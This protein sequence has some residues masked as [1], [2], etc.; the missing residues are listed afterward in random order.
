[1]GHCVL[2]WKELL[3]S[4]TRDPAYDVSQQAEAF[5]DPTE[6]DLQDLIGNLV[7][8]E[9]AKLA[10]NSKAAKMREGAREEDPLPSASIPGPSQTLYAD[11]MR[12]RNSP[13]LIDLQTQS[14]ED[15]PG[16]QDDFLAEALTSRR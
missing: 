11:L 3:P 12:N 7:R 16:R 9:L 10:L 15:N 2:Q 8:K 5:K 14:E 6:D 1:M 4:G 13:N